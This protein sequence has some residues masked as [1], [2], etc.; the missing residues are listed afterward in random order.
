MRAALRLAICILISTVKPSSCLDLHLTDASRDAVAHKQS[1]GRALVLSSHS[2]RRG[3]QELPQPQT[4]R[5][6][7]AIAFP[8]H[9][10]SDSIGAFIILVLRASSLTGR[11]FLFIV[12]P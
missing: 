2:T 10:D 7:T 8:S 5:P 1:S 11:H 12:L 4:V 9:A 3:N 6:L